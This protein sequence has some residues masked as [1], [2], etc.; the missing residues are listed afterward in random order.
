ML[1]YSIG[2]EWD[3]HAVESTDRLNAGVEPFR[4]RY[5]RARANATPMESWL[6]SMLDHAAAAEIARGWSRP[7]TFTNWLTTDPMRHPE[8]PIRKEDMVSVDAMHDWE[9]WNRVDDHER[10]K[11]GWPVVR[12]S[13][14]NAAAR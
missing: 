10:R 8:E 14:R 2:I 9:D 1:A 11:A 7:L 12:Q 4:G 6:A 5:F 3:P 13:M